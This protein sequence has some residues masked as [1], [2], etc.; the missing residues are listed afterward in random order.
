MKM[1]LA[2]EPTLEQ[3]SRRFTAAGACFPLLM[4]V[5]S[6]AKQAFVCPAAYGNPRSTGP[7][8]LQRPGNSVCEVELSWWG[9]LG[10]RGIADNPRRSPHHLKLSRDFGK[11]LCS[12]RLA[13]LVR[14]PSS[15][16][17]SRRFES[18]AAHIENPC[19]KRPC[20]GF[21]FLFD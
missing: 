11:L 6:R 13:Q 20:E 17:G 2:N 12:G 10:R 18:C 5:E 7:E 14:A 19:R 3:P 21:F 1:T 9:Q 4:V 15:H 8:D 16:G